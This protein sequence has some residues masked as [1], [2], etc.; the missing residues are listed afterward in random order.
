MGLSLLA[1]CVSASTTVSLR[2]I[3]VVRVPA[4]SIFVLKALCARDVAL[5]AMLMV[6]GSLGSAALL[7]RALSLKPSDILSTIAEGDCAWLY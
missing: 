6:M 7:A 4:F 1:N 3:G 2:S 5:L